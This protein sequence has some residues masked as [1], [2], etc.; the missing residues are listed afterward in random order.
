MKEEGKLIR[1]ARELN[2]SE[3]INKRRE[4][5]NKHE[6]GNLEGRVIRRV[7]RETV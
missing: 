4:N 2:W 5:E 7:K 6:R 1:G 3:K